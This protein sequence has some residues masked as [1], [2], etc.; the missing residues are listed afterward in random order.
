MQGLRE[1]RTL[2]TECM[3]W[4]WCCKTLGVGGRQW[5]VDNMELSLK[6]LFNWKTEV[7]RVRSPK[8]ISHGK[9]CEGG[10]DSRITLIAYFT[11]SPTSPGFACH[12]PSP[13]AGMYCPVLSLKRGISARVPI[14]AE[15]EWFP[16][17]SQLYPATVPRPNE[18]QN[19]N[20][21]NNH[22]HSKK[23][24]RQILLLSS[25]PGH[26]P[27]PVHCTHQSSSSN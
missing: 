2:K 4:S 13:T 27:P 12:V 21:N 20:S 19:N 25:N 3:V 22:E 23:I 26:K 7:R 14:T 17:E 6:E 16:R 11:A 9:R 18:K 8:F 24:W 10:Q 15:E 1:T 5:K